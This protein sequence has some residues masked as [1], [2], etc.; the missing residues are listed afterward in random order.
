M[1][2]FYNEEHRRLA[3]AKIVAVAQSILSGELGIVAG[4]RQLAALRSDVGAD[5]DSDF[6]FFV[7]VDSETDHLPLGDARSHWNPDAL[8]VKDEELR[9]FEASARNSALE[10]C[11]SLI[12]KYG[13]PDA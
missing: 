11:R 13:T 10:I 7:A 4:S 9:N 1:T 12:Q 5:R 3:S 2:T 6:L 8:K